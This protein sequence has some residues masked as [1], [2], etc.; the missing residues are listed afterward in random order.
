[1][2]SAGID[3][4]LAEADAKYGENL[5]EKIGSA[6]DSSDAMIVV[7]TKEAS[8]SPSVNQEVGYA[9]KARKL[10]V[11]MVEEGAAT[12]AM[13]QGTEVVKFT[14]DKI[15]EAIEKVTSYVHRLAKKADQEGVVWMVVGAAVAI[16][17]I[18][19]LFAL[20]ARKKRNRDD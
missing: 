18:T 9:K 7:L 5:P 6:I 16:L 19:A 15:G 12:G 10:I 4:Y 1:L 20:A 13:L 14:V 8:A 2:S 3:P 11:A 17:A